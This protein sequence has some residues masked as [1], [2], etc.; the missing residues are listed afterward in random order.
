MSLVEKALQKL[1]E[2]SAVTATVV[3]SPAPRTIH[4]EVLAEPAE[5]HAPLAAKATRIVHVDR[6]ALRAA[7]Y[8]PPQKQ[9]RRLADQFRQIKRPLLARAIGRGGE[10][11]PNGRVMLLSSSFTGEGKTFTSLNLA[12]SIAREKDV[13]AV[14][15]DAD[16]LRPQL[17]RM[18]GIE[19]W[20]YLRDIV[21]DARA[22]SCGL[23]RGVSARGELRRDREGA[24]L[25]FEL[26]GVETL[27]GRSPVFRSELEVPV[28]GP[29]RQDA[30]DVAEVLL[31]VEVMKLGGGDHGEE[32][33]GGLGVI[34][35]ADE[36]PVLAPDRDAA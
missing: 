23:V 11:V 26:G 5:R 29:V 21:S 12:F 20:A 17:S 35:G 2:T 4:A 22:P 8:L 32:V 15:I 10:A 1:R 9:E 30:E 13:F 28:L 33:R 24:K 3:A 34:V 6:D 18:L 25:C 31:G 7:G 19:P 27:P 14:L 36:E 16:V